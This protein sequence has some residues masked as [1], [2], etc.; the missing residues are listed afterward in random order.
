MGLSSSVESWHMSSLRQKFFHPLIRLSLE[1]LRPSK[2]IGNK[3]LSS[4]GLLMK[5]AMRDQIL[6]LYEISF[7]IWEPQ[8]D[9]EFSQP[10][11]WFSRYSLLPLA[12]HLFGQTDV[13]RTQE[14]PCKHRSGIRQPF[15]AAFLGLEDDKHSSEGWIYPFLPCNWGPYETASCD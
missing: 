12:F 9:L 5:R 10:R 2:C 14:G 11:V 6:V 8:T 7:L 4:M 1:A 15:S 13:M 3:S